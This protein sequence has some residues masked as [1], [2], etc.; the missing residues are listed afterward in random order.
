M[1]APIITTSLQSGAEMSDATS[2][3]FSTP[4]VPANLLL[5]LSVARVAA[6]RG[7]WHSRCDEGEACA[8]EAAHRAREH[9]TGVDRRRRDGTEDTESRLMCECSHPLFLGKIYIDAALHLP[10]RRPQWTDRGA[11]RPWIRPVR[12]LQDTRQG[13]H[14]GLSVTL[15][16]AVSHL[17]T[18]L[19][20]R[21]PMRSGSARTFLGRR[22]RGR[23][24]PQSGSERSG[25][26]GRAAAGTGSGSEQNCHVGVPPTTPTTCACAMGTPSADPV[27]STACATCAGGAPTGGVGLD[28]MACSARLRFR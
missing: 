25:V 24:R 16:T 12:P 18:H 5:L 23:P 14:H 21:G 3:I 17:S 9:P 7:R 28:P 1:P 8:A 19:H 20:C 15:R 22:R 2:G 10:P 27:I 6:Q 26:A 11:I 13:A 4:V